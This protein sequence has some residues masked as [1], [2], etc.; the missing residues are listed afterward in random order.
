M[1][2]GLGSALP[3]SAMRKPLPCV[4]LP[5]LEELGDALLRWRG[6]ET[7]G[8]K[9]ALTWLRAEGQ[10]S[11]AFQGDALRL[12]RTS[13]RREDQ[14]S[15]NYGYSLDIGLQKALG[16]PGELR[17]SGGRPYPVVQTMSEEPHISEVLSGVEQV[18]R[19][20]LGD[21]GLAVNVDVTLMP[22]EGRPWSP[23]Y[24]DGPTCYYSAKRRSPFLTPKPRWVVEVDTH[25]GKTL[26]ADFCQV[27]GKT[28]SD[29]PHLAASF[30]G[31]TV[32]LTHCLNPTIRADQSKLVKACGGLL[33]PSF[34]IG[35]V[36]AAPFGAL[37][38]VATPSLALAGMRPYKS[39]RGHWPIV[40]YDTDAW[41]SGT[42][43]FLGDGSA[44]LFADLTGAPQEWTYKNHIWTLG[45]PYVTGSLTDPVRI[46]S[47]K[48]LSSRLRAL[49]KRFPQSLDATELEARSSM[50]KDRYPYI[51]CKSNL[52]VAPGSIRLAV[53]PASM[54]KECQAFLR[55]SGFGT[56]KLMTVS[57]HPDEPAPGRNGPWDYGWAVSEAVLSIAWREG[58][59]LRV[60]IA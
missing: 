29:D 57:E 32:L 50:D 35:E 48:R 10:V 33:F 21:R 53:C 34:A 5:E 22:E 39:G 44:E 4:M 55:A 1:A 30:A 18:A 3:V 47:T 13:V 6:V 15:W 20:F 59:M 41:T 51:E 60:E 38:L 12:L 58:T 25:E 40:A 27:V 45:P 52:I 11:V 43:T 23:A 42:S 54:R 7:M 2:L 36:P 26:G 8:A 24:G 28:D 56:V 9:D 31:H 14:R 37:V 17:P 46:E 19:D 49:G 16:F